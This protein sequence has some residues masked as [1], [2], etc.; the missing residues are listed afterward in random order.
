MLVYDLEGLKL[1]SSE[2]VH[3]LLSGDWRRVQQAEGYRW[4]LVNG[5]V[6]LEDGKPTGNVSGRPLRH[7]RG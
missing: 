1:L 7:G 2:V 6:T 3:D 5:Q 4:T